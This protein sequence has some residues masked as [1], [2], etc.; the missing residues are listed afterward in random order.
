V[1]QVPAYR[2]IA[3]RNLNPLLAQGASN[4][5]QE[6]LLRAADQYRRAS[7][8]DKRFDRP[9]AVEFLV[10]PAGLTRHDRQPKPRKRTRNLLS[11]K[12][13]A[14]CHGDV[15]MWAYDLFLYQCSWTSTGFASR[16]LVRVPQ[17]RWMSPE[18]GQWRA[19]RRLLSPGGLATC[20]SSA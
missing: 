20:T 1:G 3:V 6:Q 7:Q 18:S 13:V 10:E 19:E 15:V 8:A 11:L 5:F 14:G 16:T 2:P 4:P 17:R 12:S 9:T